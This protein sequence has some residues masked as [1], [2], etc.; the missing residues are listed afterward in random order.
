MFVIHVHICINYTV[1]SDIIENTSMNLLKYYANIAEFLTDRKQCVRSLT[2][3]V[4]TMV[5]S[6]RLIKYFVRSELI[7]VERFIRR[8]RF[9]IRL[10]KSSTT[11]R[12]STNSS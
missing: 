6:V 4:E 1:Y 9:L 12:F 11:I 2:N 5:S 8:A 10:R 3:V 7:H